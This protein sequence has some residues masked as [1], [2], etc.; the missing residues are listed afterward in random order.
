MVAIL[1][2]V[3][4]RL[5]F[6]RHRAWGC[7][8]LMK[9]TVPRPIRSPFSAVGEVS[10]GCWTRPPDPARVI[11]KG[12]ILELMPGVGGINKSYPSTGE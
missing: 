4:F 5:L 2:T 7:G 9:G 12:R 10:T 3:I 11:S 6:A 8:K 1:I